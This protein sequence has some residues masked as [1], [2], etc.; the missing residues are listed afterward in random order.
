MGDYQV[1]HKM[2][3]ASS[4]DLDPYGNYFFALEISTTSGDAKKDSANFKPVGHFMECSGL[5]TSATVFEFEEGGMNGRS[6]KR[7]GQSK[8]ENIVLR[9][10]TSADD[11]LMKWRDNWLMDDFTSRK[12]YSGSIT[13]RDNYGNVIRRYSFK[14]AWPVSWE[15]PSMNSGGSELAIETLEIAHDGLII[16][17][18]EPDSAS[19]T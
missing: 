7:P 5:K 12:T 17:G 18:S 19:N 16:S 11:F 9:Y 6:H 8:W 15:G 3:K 13:L 14:N 2:E 10:A 1:R 4:V